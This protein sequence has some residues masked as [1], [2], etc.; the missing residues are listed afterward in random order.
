[1]KADFNEPRKHSSEIN[2]SEVSQNIKLFLFSSLQTGRTDEWER[3]SSQTCFFYV[4]TSHLFGS[5]WKDRQDNYEWMKQEP[6]TSLGVNAYFPV[7]CIMVILKTIPKNITTFQGCIDKRWIFTS[8]CVTSVFKVVID[9]NMF[10]LF[11]ILSSFC[12][13]SKYSL[14]T[15]T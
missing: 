7:F 3:W 2:I 5:S 8:T 4:F 13:S 6:D 14:L 1:M 9:L 11:R 10:V 15:D 12:L